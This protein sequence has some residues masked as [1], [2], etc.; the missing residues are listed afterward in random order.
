MIVLKKCRF[1]GAEAEIQEVFHPDKKGLYKYQVVCPNSKC[2]V[3][4]YTRLKATK[5]EA[6]EIWNRRVC[7]V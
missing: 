3:S 1:C 2:E 5:E 7:D 4:V 6:A